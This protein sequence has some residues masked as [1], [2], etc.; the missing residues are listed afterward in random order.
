VHLLHS[1]P[2]GISQFSTQEEEEARRQEEEKERI[3]QEERELIARLPRHD[4]LDLAKLGA[5]EQTPEEHE[6]LLSTLRGA[7]KTDFTGSGDASTS[8]SDDRHDQSLIELKKQFKNM[9][10]VSRAKVT[11]DR[12]YSAVF[13]ADRTKDLIFFG[14]NA[15]LSRHGRRLF[16]GRR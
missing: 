11:L 6:A 3:A 9:A 5:D 2:F 13:H 15:R 7:S 10:I 16:S 12:V 14:G 4:D 1:C 8:Y